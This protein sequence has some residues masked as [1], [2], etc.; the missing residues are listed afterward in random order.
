MPKKRT[1]KALS[2][3]LIDTPFFPLLFIAEF[4]KQVVQSGPF[5]VEHGVLAV[6]CV[7]LWILSDAISVE[8]D[9]VIGDGGGR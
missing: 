5:V 1:F 3:E 8:M 4:V 6:I 7:I 9:D 2:K